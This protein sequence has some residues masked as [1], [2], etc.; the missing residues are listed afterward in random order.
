MKVE[1]NDDEDPW[2]EIVEEKQ[3]DEEIDKKIDE[4]NEEFLQENE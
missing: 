2:D 4:V 1:A 3:D